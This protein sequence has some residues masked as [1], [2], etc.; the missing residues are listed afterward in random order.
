MTKA[1]QQP[2][3]QGT[4][5]ASLY[6]VAHQLHQ[7]TDMDNLVHQSLHEALALFGA[8]SGCLILYDRRGLPMRWLT[9]DESCPLS[10]SQLW[11]AL[12]EGFVGQ[13]LQQGRVAYVP[14]VLDEPVPSFITGR[15]LVA[16]PLRTT[17]GVLGVLLLSHSKPGGFDPYREKEPLM[18]ALAETVGLAVQNMWLFTDLRDKETDRTQYMVG[19]LVHDIRSPLT[20]VSASFEVIERALQHFQGEEKMRQFMD[21]SLASAR[22]ALQQ[23]TTLTNDLLDVRKLQSGNQKPDVQSIALELLYDEIHKLMYNLALRHKVIIR[24]QVEPRLL[25]VIADV[26]LLRRCLI[27]LAANALRFSPERGTIMMKAYPAP[28]GEGIVL[29]VEDMGPGVPPEERERIFEP[30][31]QAK[32]ESGRGT[33]LGLTFCR[34]VALSHGGKI[35]VE[36]RDG[37]GSRFC[38]LLPHR[39]DPNAE[40]SPLEG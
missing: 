7:S 10:E 1:H 3:P 6:H 20:A 4:D 27:N 25:R 18:S 31:A 19:L 23:V 28:R 5:W 39:S 32:G 37:G 13:V 35:W 17:I 33:G 26:D 9:S 2:Q 16:L 30:F 34:E 38:M 14:D 21:E 22:R 8:E 12:H 36:D 29:V 15:S 40:T 11:L 24:Y